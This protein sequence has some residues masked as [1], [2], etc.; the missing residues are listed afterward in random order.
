MRYVVWEGEVFVVV[1]PA[2]VIDVGEAVVADLGDVSAVLAMGK[3]EKEKENTY[4]RDY[5]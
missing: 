1:V 5:G 2:W 3:G 4:A